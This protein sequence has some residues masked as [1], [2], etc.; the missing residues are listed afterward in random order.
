MRSALFAIF[1]CSAAAQR[2]VKRFEYNNIAAKTLT[3]AGD[4]LFPGSDISFKRWKISDPLQTEDYEAS[5]VNGIISNGTHAVV[6][7][8]SAGISLFVIGVPN[9]IFG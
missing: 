5:S 7:Q 3:V 9:K 2:I 6:A 4:D 8:Y 1:L